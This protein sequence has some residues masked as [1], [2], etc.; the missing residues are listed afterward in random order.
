MEPGLN[1]TGVSYMTNI[2]VYI[3]YTLNLEETTAITNLKT[4]KEL[5]TLIYTPN[6]AAL[7]GVHP[8]PDQTPPVS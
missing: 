1:T 6:T 3:L 8:H 2:L 7:V 5:D 4:K